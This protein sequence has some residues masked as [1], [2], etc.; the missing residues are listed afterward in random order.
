MPFAHTLLQEFR[1]SGMGSCMLHLQMWYPVA[2]TQKC[3]VHDTLLLARDPN[4]D[5]SIR[6]TT[7]LLCTGDRSCRRVYLHP[8]CGPGYTLPL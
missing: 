5:K 2:E 1:H 3:P 7:P 6:F 4:T 8:L